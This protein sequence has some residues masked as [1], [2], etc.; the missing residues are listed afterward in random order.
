MP[1][2]CISKRQR[3]RMRCQRFIY[4]LYEAARWQN[5]NSSEKNN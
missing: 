3:A 4:G 5:H 1:G 2:P